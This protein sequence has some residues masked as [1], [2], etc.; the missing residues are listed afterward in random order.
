MSTLLKL[1]GKYYC[2]I[3]WTE[4]GKT[5]NKLIGLKTKQAAKA[6]RLKSKIDEREKLFRQGIINVDDIQKIEYPAIESL[7]DCYIDDL[8]IREVNQRTIEL[9]ELA[10][11]DFKEVFKDQDIDTIELENFRTFLRKKHAN[12]HTANIKIRTINSFVNYLF[13]SGKLKTKP[14]RISQFKTPEK[15]PHYFSN[16]ELVRILIACKKRNLE[17]YYR[18]YLHLNTGLR[19]REL[20]RAE[21]KGNL[22]SIYNPCKRGNNRTIPVNDITRKYFVWCKQNGRY[23]H[24]VISRMFTEVISELGLYKLSDGS[25]RHF[26]NLRDTFA[27]VA[28]YLTRDIFQVAKWLGHTNKGL[29]AVQTTAIYANFDGELLYQDFGEKQTVIKDL[30]E[31]LLR[32]YTLNSTT[33]TKPKTTPVQSF[34]YDFVYN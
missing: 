6:N 27:T 4:S 22:I 13:K 10:L 17:L 20:D 9:Y 5:K 1:R 2:R 32:N 16:S 24:S 34:N 3:R 15:S 11:N 19:L 8:K 23:N 33:T 29:P 21:L 7:V 26:H 14:E 18:V 12:P 25:T 31:A 30:R 28:Y